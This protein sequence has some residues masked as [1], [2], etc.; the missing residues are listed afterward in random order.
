VADGAMLAVPECEVSVGPESS[1]GGPSSRCHGCSPYELPCAL[2]SLLFDSP[3]FLL[4]SLS[5]LSLFVS[6]SV[7]QFGDELAAV[8]ADGPYS[9][10]AALDAN[11]AGL[12]VPFADPGVGLALEAFGAEVVGLESHLRSTIEMRW[13]SG[14]DVFSEN[15]GV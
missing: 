6:K 3:G 10:P 12:N 2:V 8:E 1:S 4:T 11:V 13:D 14:D 15:R 9:H 5:C 7:S